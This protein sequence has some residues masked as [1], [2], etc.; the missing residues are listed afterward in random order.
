MISGRRLSIYQLVTPNID[1]YAAYSIA[2]V[3]KYAQKHNYGFYIQREKVEKDMHINWTKIAMLQKAA[4]TN[5]E[6]T[7]LIDAD[8]VLVNQ[9]FELDRWMNNL[10]TKKSILMTKDTPLL[11]RNRPNAGVILFKNKEGKKIMDYWL[12]A[13][14]NEGSHLADT[15]PRNQHVYWNYVQPKYQDEQVL[16]PNA[17]ASK[18]HWFVPYLPSNKRFLFHFT[19]SDAAMRTKNMESMYEKYIGDSQLLSEVTQ[20]L[21]ENQTG[22]LKIN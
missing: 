13:A 16:V 12:H 7:L 11:K 3:C 22:L 9:S 8:T 6:F 4:E 1:G 17:F 2:S 20:Q 19:Q 5:E 10:N 14:K 15:H 21:E 18:Y